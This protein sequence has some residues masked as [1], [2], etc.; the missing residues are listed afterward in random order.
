MREAETS[1]R[2]LV[3]A[4]DLDDSV[5]VFGAYAS[6]ELAEL[7]IAEFEKIHWRFSEWRVEAWKP[8]LN[9]GR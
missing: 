6:E 9:L 3:M 8:A 1:G 2:F 7:A 5:K 4:L